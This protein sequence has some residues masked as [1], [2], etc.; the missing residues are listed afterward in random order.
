MSKNQIIKIILFLVIALSFSFSFVGCKEPGSNN[1]GDYNPHEQP[2]TGGGGS[3]GQQNNDGNKITYTF[4]GPEGESITLSAAQTLSWEKDEKIT[5]NVTEVFD[6]YQWRV[7][8][9]INGTTGNSITLSARN[10]GTGTHTV[11]LKVTI[12]SITY[13]KTIYFTVN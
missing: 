5:I 1:P 11:S 7:N 12:G 4:T 8:G 13:T 6:S 2:S 9:M 3:S 10:L